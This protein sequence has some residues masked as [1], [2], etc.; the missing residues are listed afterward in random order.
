LCTWKWT[1]TIGFGPM[2]ACGQILVRYE[3]VGTSVE[4]KPMEPE[5]FCELA[6]SSEIFGVPATGPGLFGNVLCGRSKAM[7]LKWSKPNRRTYPVWSGSHKIICKQDHRH[8][9]GT[10]CAHDCW[11]EEK[12]LRVLAEA[13]GGPEG[14]CGSLKHLK[15][16]LCAKTTWHERSSCGACA[17][18]GM[19]HPV[20]VSRPVAPDPLGRG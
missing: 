15:H 3:R 8:R 4:G 1:T 9:P 14:G 5:R 18:K 13:T 7:S 17:T 2:I 12:P 10:C 19:P 11:C 16:R 20:L 6:C